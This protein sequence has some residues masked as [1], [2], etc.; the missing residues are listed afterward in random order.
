MISVIIPVYNMEG[1]LC[2]CVDSVLTQTYANLEVILVDDGSV[3]G[4]GRIAD[5]Y[6]AA[7]TRVKVLHR[8]NGG[9]SAARNSGLDAAGGDWIAFVDADDWI[10]PDAF[11]KLTA[12]CVDAEV[13]AFGQFEERP[14][15]AVK[16]LPA[17]KPER[18]TGEE[19]VERMILGEGI[20]VS[21]WDKLYRR[22][23]FEGIRFPEGYNFED[24]RTTWKLLEKA[25]SVD[26]IPEPLYHYVQRRGS[27][28]HSG[29][30][31]NQLDNWTAFYELYRVF[32]SRD[33]KTRSVCVRRCLKS[34]VAAWDSLWRTDRAE[35]RRE[36]ERIAQIV[37]FVRE[38][39]EEAAKYG[40]RLRVET[41]LTVSGT[42]ASMLCVYLIRT[43]GRRGRMKKLFPAE[44]EKERRPG[45]RRARQNSGKEE[46]RK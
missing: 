26:L 18:I 16:R 7:D 29:S 45:R 39:R 40:I 21:V 46:V 6:T 41:A 36:K 27:L 33:E 4:S 44:I 22:E 42:R 43:P 15:G 14:A 25:R 23:L 1:T 11:E 5:E 10:E 19:A 2:R 31:K 13:C 38:H 35:R 37:R 20:R 28:C 30:A 24:V 8:E 32:G 9:L 3:D 12:A 34:A 17:D